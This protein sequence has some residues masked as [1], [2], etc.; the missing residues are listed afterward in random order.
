MTSEGS[1]GTENVNIEMTGEGIGKP[2]PNDCQ[3]KIV[4]ERELKYS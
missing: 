1:L 3:Q 2:V 4:E